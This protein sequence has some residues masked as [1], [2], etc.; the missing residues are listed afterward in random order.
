MQHYNIIECNKVRHSSLRAASPFLP[1]PL[2]RLPHSS[3]FACLLQYPY[4][5]LIILHALPSH[6]VSFISLAISLLSSATNTHRHS[7]CLT[8]STSPLSQFL[9]SRSPLLNPHHLPVYI[10]LFPLVVSPSSSFASYTLSPHTAPCIRHPLNSQ[11]LPAL[12]VP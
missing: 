10:L 12:A 1:H 4:Y 2:Q 11:S 6:H 9:Q 3:I 8:S 7:K 5:P